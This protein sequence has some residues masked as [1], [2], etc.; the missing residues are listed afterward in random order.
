MVFLSLLLTGCNPQDA[1]VS[2]QYAFLMADSSSD[3]LNL[4]RF[5]GD[6]A[7]QKDLTPIDCRTLASEDD[8]LEGANTDCAGQSTVWFPWLQ[9][10]SYYLKEGKFDDTIWRTE[11]LL[12]SEGDLQLTIHSRIEDYGDVRFGWVIKPDFQ[13][14]ICNGTEDGGAILEDIDGDWLQNWSDHPDDAGYTVWN[15]NANSFQ[16]NPNNTDDYWGFLP[17]WEAGYSFG[18]FGDEDLAHHAS[19][20]NDMSGENGEF[21]VSAADPS[22]GSRPLYYPA[23]ANGQYKVRPQNGAGVDDFPG[24]SDKTLEEWSDSIQAYLTDNNDLS[25][26]VGSDFPISYRVNSNAW[27][28]AD[29]LEPGMDQ[30]AE[31]DLGYVRIKNPQDIAAGKLKNPVT[32]DFQIYLEGANSASKLF[33]KGSF[34]IDHISEDTFYNPTLEAAKVEENQ[35]SRCE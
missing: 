18:R 11:A 3:A 16:F 30:W 25:R 21:W 5:R 20:Y 6:F 4:L 33:I 29:A 17:E 8:R 1:E 28:P 14:K 35:P 22:Y 9:F 7:K 15:L 2:A 19:D 13:P 10:Y 31:V 27:R 32:G 26:M 24:A 23:V 12:T 34:T